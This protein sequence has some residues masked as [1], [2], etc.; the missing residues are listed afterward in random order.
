MDTI[1]RIIERNDVFVEVSFLVNRCDRRNAEFWI[2]RQFYYSL[3][4]LQYE[5]WIETVKRYYLVPFGQCKESDKL[6]DVKIEKQYSLQEIIERS[7]K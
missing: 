7:I 5:E 6:T 4:N 2:D 1:E 3:S